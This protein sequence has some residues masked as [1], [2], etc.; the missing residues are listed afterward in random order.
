M[1]KKEKRFSWKGLSGK[2]KEQGLCG[3]EQTDLRLT[4]YIL[5]AT[6][7]RLRDN[8]FERSSETECMRVCANRAIVTSQMNHHVIWIVWHTL[9]EREKS[10]AKTEVKGLLVENIG[11]WMLHTLQQTKHQKT[12]IAMDSVVSNWP[13]RHTGPSGVFNRIKLKRRSHKTYKASL[14]I[15]DQ[16]HSY[17]Q[18]RE[19]S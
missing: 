9:V 2:E 13:A 10:R 18:G 7:C 11:V 16:K 14:F 12:R 17:M 1:R 15:K 4:C 6:Q 3:W 19:N 8:S 5:V